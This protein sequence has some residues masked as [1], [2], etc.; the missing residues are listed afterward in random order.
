MLILLLAA[1]WLVVAVLTL[2]ACRAAGLADAAAS[3]ARSERSACETRPRRR[4]RAAVSRRSRQYVR[5]GARTARL[6]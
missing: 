5:P 4:G 2:A 3:A 1:I 6:T